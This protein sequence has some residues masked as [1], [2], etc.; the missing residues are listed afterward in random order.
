MC[1]F[2]TPKI[3]ATPTP[4]PPAPVQQNFTADVTTANSD[5]K[6][7]QASANGFK[8]TIATSGLGVAQAPTVKQNT[9]L[10]QG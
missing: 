9:L 1:L 10:G 3:P 4:A 7:R 2:S 6:R 5:E 8:S